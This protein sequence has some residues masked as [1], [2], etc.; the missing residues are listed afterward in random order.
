MPLRV[1]PRITDNVDRLKPSI[2]MSRKSQTIGDFTVSRPSQILPRYRGK[3][4]DLRYSSV[5]DAIFICWG[6]GGGGK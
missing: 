3:S 5:T 6:G 4:P 1:S 2:H